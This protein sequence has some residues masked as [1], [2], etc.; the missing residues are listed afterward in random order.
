[1]Q[2]LSHYRPIGYNSARVMTLELSGISPRYLT[3]I[4]SMA[5]KLTMYA[6]ASEKYR[7]RIGYQARSILIEI[8]KPPNYWKQVTLDYLQEKQLLLPG[9][10]ATLGL[11]LQDQPMRIDFNQPD[12]AHL[13]ITGQTRSGKTNTQQLITWELCKNGAKVILIDVAKKNYKWGVF[14]RVANLIHPLCVELAETEKI[15]AWCCQEILRR[16]Q[17]PGKREP[18]FI[19]IDELKTLVDDSELA[20]QYLNRIAAIGGEFG[21]HLILSTQYPQI[22]MLGSAELKRN[23]ATRLC[24]RVDDAMAAQ[25]ALGIK[26]SGASALQGYGD[27]LLK[28]IDGLNRLTIARI[29]DKHIAQLPRVEAQHSYP[30]MWQSR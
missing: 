27:F 10:V 21:L 20:K 7:V 30:F 22:N 3:T 8:P 2:G 4:R 24:G 18:I 28:D 29:E 13:F 26:N 17:E 25:N 14:S 19:I 23:I 15:L 16:A 1:M 11:G 9:N 12:I 5:D 6:G